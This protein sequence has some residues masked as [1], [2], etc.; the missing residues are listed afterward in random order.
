M[1][2][3]NQ[4]DDDLTNSS[5]SSEDAVED[6]VEDVVEDETAK[7]EET[8]NDD[9]LESP[10]DDSEE[11]V[12]KPETKFN[13]I[14]QEPDGQIIRVGEELKFSATPHKNF[15]IVDKDVYQ[16]VRLRGTKRTAFQLVYTAG[17]AIPLSKLNQSK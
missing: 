5:S 17:T 3:E 15:A 2:S 4:T 9:D 16:E 8:V 10:E 11:E 7:V 14:G 12:L 13:G 6:V 1:T